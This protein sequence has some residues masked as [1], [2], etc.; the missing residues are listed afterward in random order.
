MQHSQA[1]LESE[2]RAVAKWGSLETSE[3]KNDFRRRLNILMSGASLVDSGM[4][5]QMLTL[6]LVQKLSSTAANDELTETLYIIRNLWCDDQPVC[7]GSRCST[8]KQQ[9]FRYNVVLNL[10]L[11]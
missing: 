1:K 8:R 9:S 2:A 3:L 5:F 7:N 11:K 10:G 4:E 6:S